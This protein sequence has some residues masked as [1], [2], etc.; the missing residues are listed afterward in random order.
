VRQAEHL[1]EANALLPAVLQGKIKPPSPS[2]TLDF[3]LVCQYRKLFGAAARFYQEAF[4]GRPELGEDLNLGFRYSAACAAA[5]A[6]VG[7]GADMLG[8]EERT[9]WRKQALAWLRADLELWGRR[10]EKGTPQAWAT[11]ERSLRHWQHDADL[12]GLREEGALARLPE[13][14]RGAYRKLWADVNALLTRMKGRAKG[15]RS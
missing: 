13:A 4:N 9:R 12:A 2:R 7:R 11:V 14:E 6:G 8:E 10:L 1:V 3:A 5:L 15:L